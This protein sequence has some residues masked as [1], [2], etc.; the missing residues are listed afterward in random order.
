MRTPDGYHV[1][2]YDAEPVNLHRPSVD[3]L[4]ESAA[5]VAG[6]G[7]LGVILT[8]MG[9]DGARGLRAMRDRGAHTLAQDENTSLVFGMP[10]RAIREGGV[11]DV[12]ALDRMADRFL[13][14]AG[15][16]DVEHPAA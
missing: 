10:E 8:G 15:V 2:V 1:R 9:K 12:V 4:F 13:D 3:V 16:T 14:W 11:V 7:A 6:A 5:R